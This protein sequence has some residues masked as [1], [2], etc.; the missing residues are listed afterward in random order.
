[1]CHCA[2]HFLFFFFKRVRERKTEVRTLEKVLRRSL[3]HTDLIEMS[4]KKKKYHL[5]YKR[6]VA[7]RGFV[8]AVT[9]VALYLQGWID[10]IYLAWPVK[11][12]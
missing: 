4:K 12:A 9:V 2:I 7:L 3:G 10:C 5:H 6:E 1:M 8:L 11:T